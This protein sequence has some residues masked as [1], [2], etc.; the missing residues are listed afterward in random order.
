MNNTTVTNTTSLLDP[1]SAFKKLISGIKDVN[2]ALSQFV[3]IAVD[4][5]NK[6]FH[7][8][9]STTTIVFLSQLI[10]WFVLFLIVKKFFFGRIRLIFYVIILFLALNSLLS[11][12]G[13]DILKMLA[14]G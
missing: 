13:F 9:L 4:N 7:L 6:M 8:N 12:T 1:I 5:I 11:F 14:G 10:T 2:D 3:G